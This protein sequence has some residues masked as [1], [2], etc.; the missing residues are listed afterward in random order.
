M[1]QRATERPLDLERF[2]PEALSET[3][4]LLVPLFSSSPLGIA[5]CDK[6]LRFRAI[7]N[8]LAAMNGIP[9]EAHLGKTVRDVVGP[10]ASQVEPAFKRV[11]ATGEKFS[12]EVAGKL[13]KRA[14]WGYWIE[15]YYPIRDR[16]G[17]VKQVC[18]T[19]IEISRIK[20]L[21][22]S[23]FGLTG[24]L[25]D[26][27]AA[28]KPSIDANF[29]QHVKA[30]QT[31]QSAKLFERCVSEILAVCQG[32]SPSL[33]KT[34]EISTQAPPVLASKVRDSSLSISSIPPA[35]CISDR[36]CEVLRLLVAGRG[37]KEVAATLD[38]SVRTVEAHR[39]KIMLKLGIHSFAELV[40]YAVRHGLIDA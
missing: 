40:R 4:Q 20:K 16:Q 6:G 23:L 34:S 7:N 10:V 5:F 17:K 33:P 39:T 36:E 29:V 13:P 26:V 18:V 2:A 21:E 32:L 15:D 14:E 11:F 3:G 37:N 1:K 27:F 38:I 31:A 30:M 24:K 35:N 25:L 19:V 9:A 22:E 12:I 28:L 8:T